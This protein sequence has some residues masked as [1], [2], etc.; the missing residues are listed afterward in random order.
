MITTNQFFDQ[1]QEEEA[2]I[3]CLMTANTY[4]GLSLE[5]K[6]RIATSGDILL[7]TDRFDN[8]EEYKKLSKEYYRAKKAKRNYEIDNK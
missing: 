1:L 2:Y 3:S 7:K 5:N 4:S 6:E 8:D